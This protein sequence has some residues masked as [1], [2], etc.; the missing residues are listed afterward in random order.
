MNKQT[1]KDPTILGA[2]AGSGMFKVKYKEQLLNEWAVDNDGCFLVNQK[3]ISK[4]D[5]DSLADYSYLLNDC[6]L[7][8]RHISSITEEEEEALE[9]IPKDESSCRTDSGVTYYIESPKSFLYLLSIGILPPNLSEDGVEF[10]NQ[11][12]ND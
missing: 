8:A 9:S 10:V 12:E 5:D 3:E 11:K 4:W 6:T 1:W 2:I 7:I